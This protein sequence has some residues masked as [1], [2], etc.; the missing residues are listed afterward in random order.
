M[1]KYIDC[2]WLDEEPKAIMPEDIENVSS[3]LAE[4]YSKTEVYEGQEWYIGYTGHIPEKYLTLHPF[5]RRKRMGVKK[6]VREV[7]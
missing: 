3:K 4:Y 6:K 1:K 7:K 5:Y 2:V